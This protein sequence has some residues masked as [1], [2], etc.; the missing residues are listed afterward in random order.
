MAPATR[1]VWIGIASALW[2]LMAIVVLWAPEWYWVLR[3]WNAVPVLLL[4]VAWLTAW[5]SRWFAWTWGLMS[6]A[7]IIALWNLADGLFWAFLIISGTPSARYFQDQY[8]ELYGFCLWPTF[9]MSIPT[10]VFA[11]FWQ[12]VP[13]GRGDRCAIAA[14]LLAWL[15]VT[16]LMRFLVMSAEV[17]FD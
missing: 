11:R 2:L 3:A 16:L 6:L 14:A 5:S 1:W 13:T 8:I 10:Y 17:M 15:N 7:W 12:H 9:M 4:F